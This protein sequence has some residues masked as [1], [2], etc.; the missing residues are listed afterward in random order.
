MSK[1]LICNA[2]SDL[3]GL[4]DGAF[5]FDG[6][7]KTQCLGKGNHQKPTKT[8]KIRFFGLINQISIEYP[9]T[10]TTSSWGEYIGPPNRF[11]LWFA[12]VFGSR[13]YGRCEGLIVNGEWAFWDF[14]TG[15]FGDGVKELKNLSKT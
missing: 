9:E 2:C 6:I 15:L 14:E 10:F 13:E 8:E 3:I 7:I 11:M 12:V 4:I 5:G 1:P